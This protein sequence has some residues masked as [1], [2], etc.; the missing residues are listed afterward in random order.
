M[1][2]FC[3]RDA[4]QGA[5]EYFVPWNHSQEEAGWRGIEVWTAA[6]EVPAT[7]LPVRG[8]GTGSGEAAVH[9]ANRLGVGHFPGWVGRE[10]GSSGNQSELNVVRFAGLRYSPGQSDA[11]HEARALNLR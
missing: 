10:L 6:G 2:G 5:R 11:W 8:Y 7:I 1:T 4:G 3:G 9:I